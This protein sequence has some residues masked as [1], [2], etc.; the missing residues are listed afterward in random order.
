MP[1]VR[2]YDVNSHENERK[3]MK[4]EVFV[5]TFDWLLATMYETKGAEGFVSIFSYNDI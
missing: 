1:S 3:T 4:S 2:I 5:Q